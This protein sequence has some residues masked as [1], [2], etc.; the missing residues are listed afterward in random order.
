MLPFEAY[1]MLFE[2]LTTQK[3]YLEIKSIVSG[4]IDW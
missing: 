4:T 3:G 2:E 1:L